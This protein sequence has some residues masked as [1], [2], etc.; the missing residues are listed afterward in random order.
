M[1]KQ[2]LRGVYAVFAEGGLVGL[3]QSGLSDGGGGL[4]FMNGL[5]AAAPAQALHAAGDRAG[6]DENDFASLFAQAGDLAS[7]VADGIQVEA[8]AVVGDE[9]RADLDDQALG[10]GEA[11]L[12]HASSVV[13]SSSSLAISGMAICSR[14]SWMA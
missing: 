6:G 4:F 12:A 14:A 1:G 13:P 2:N 9:C 3:D 5:W 7:P 8:C 10:V 11:G